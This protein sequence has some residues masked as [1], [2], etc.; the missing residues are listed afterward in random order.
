MS[1]KVFAVIGSNSFTGSHIVS[2]LLEDSSNFVIGLSRS[3][4]KSV[5]FLPYKNKKYNLNKFRFFQ[6]DFARQTD[7]LLTILDEFRPSCII[8]L[9]ALNEVYLSN[10]RPLEYFQTNCLGLINLCFNLKTRKYLEKYVHIS[11]AEVYGNCSE[12]LMESAPLYPSTPYAVSKATADMYLATL[13]K[14]FDFPV[15]IVR[16]T[17]VYGKH[18]LLHK[19]IPRTIINLKK[20]EKTKLH[21]GGHAVK[22]W[23]HVS[24]VANGVVTISQLGKPGEIYHFSDV[25]SYS[26]K[27]LVRKICH[28]M[29]YDFESSVESVEE[30]LGQDAQ[31]L[32]D[33]SKAERELSWFPQIS[34][35]QGLKETIAWLEEEWDQVSKE[36]L[37]YVHQA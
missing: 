6:N 4:E 24:D 17:N 21:G 20:G 19:I 27:D 29:G 28:F 1:Q 37:V 16:S 30:R 7:Q 14:N 26:I 12:P 15:M 3:P 33:Y 9:A 23:I 32:L 5:F 18:Q 35:D 22:T 36:S 8:N 11:S 13:F 34:F 2:T 25:N 31:Y 10:F